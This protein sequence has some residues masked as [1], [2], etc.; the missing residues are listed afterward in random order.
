M[1]IFHLYDQQFTSWLSVNGTKHLKLLLAASWQE[2]IPD[3]HNPTAEKSDFWFQVERSVSGL[4]QNNT[5]SS[6]SAWMQLGKTFI[7][8]FRASNVFDATGKYT[9]WESARIYGL[10]S[11]IPDSIMEHIPEEIQDDIQEVRPFE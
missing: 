4:E 2:E 6:L 8:H 9:N 7:F 5:S 3:N 1:S 10:S 11:A